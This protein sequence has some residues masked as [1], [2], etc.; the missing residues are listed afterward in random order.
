MILWFEIS[1]SAISTLFNMIKHTWSE[2]LWRYNF[3]NPEQSH[4]QQTGC[5]QN[6]EPKLVKKLNLRYWFCVKKK[7]ELLFQIPFPLFSFFFYAFIICVYH[8]IG[9]VE[10]G[11]EGACNYYSTSSSKFKGRRSPRNGCWTQILKSQD[12]QWQAKFHKIKRAAFYKR[13]W[14]RLKISILLI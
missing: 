13:I 14:E 4:W 8:L 2:W 9:E 7:I 5:F 11:I 6:F 3:H 12:H 10:E 1:E